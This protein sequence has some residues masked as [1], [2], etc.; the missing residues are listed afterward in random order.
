MSTSSS[1]FPASLPVLSPI[2]F[3][4]PS[5]SLFLAVSDI[6][7]RFHLCLFPF[8]S[9]IL[10]PGVFTFAASRQILFLF[11]PFSL[12]CTLSLGSSLCSSLPD[13]LSCSFLPSSPSP[14]FPILRFFHPSDPGCPGLSPMGLWEPG[15]SGRWQVRLGMGLPSNHCILS[16][17]FLLPS[18]SCL[19][20]DRAGLGW[21]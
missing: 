19:P 12:F 5:V 10:S 16:S 3:S 7:L 18:N 2:S 15:T 1:P 14:S 9:C 21:W 17:Q 6:R 8:H 11:L 13:S 20:R 4:S